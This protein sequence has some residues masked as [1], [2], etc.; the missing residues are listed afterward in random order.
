MGLSRFLIVLLAT[1]GGALSAAEQDAA[2]SGTAVAQQ[3]LLEQ[4]KQI[5]L[6]GK[7]PNGDSI[8]ARVRGDITLQGSQYACAGCHR[9]SGLGS[10]E[11][12]NVIP[13]VIGNSL[14][15]P[16]VTHMHKQFT[17]LGM[18]NETR[19]AYTTQLLARA[20]REG[21][22]PAGRRLSPLMPRFALTDSDVNAV[23]AY[24]SSLSV[25]LPPGIDDQAIHFATIATPGNEA[26]RNAMLG[27]FTAFFDVKNERTRR[28]ISRSQRQFYD[29]AWLYESYR[30]WELHVWELSGPEQ[31]WPAQLQRLYTEQP[32]FAVL[33]GVGSGDWLGVHR[34]CEEQELPCLLPNIPFPPE[35]AD[36]DFYSVYFSRGVALEA[37][38]LATVLSA[39]EQPPKSML[40]VRRDNPAAHAAAA[41]L[42]QALKGE[43][44]VT[45]TDLVLEQEEAASAGFWSE[46]ARE[47]GDSTWVLWLPGE[48]LEGLATLP[49]TNPATIYL[50]ATLNRDLTLLQQHPLHQR[51]TLLSPYLPPGKEA[52]TLGVRALANR[53][54]LPPGEWHVQSSSYLAASLA[55]ETLKQMRS[56]LSRDYFIERIEHMMEDM[57]NS[58]LYP[59]LSLAPGQRF[60][61]K[62]CYVWE[63]GKDFASAKWVVP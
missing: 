52:N 37:Q 43:A 35:Q 60:A 26:A 32:V 14:F 27:I 61:A 55:A 17:A 24:L 46:L 62:G 1:S 41:T 19:P 56:D 10:I 23:A 3:E 58:S 54:K 22:D 45:L 57:V 44:K 16:R 30:P 48:D 33:G 51:F 49:A 31:S 2:P 50:S 12:D 8:R 25:G 36:R 5:Y 7:L 53:H 29:N 21:I 4:G 63:M 6:H 20:L 11:G 38:T 13:P 9:R 47:H 15:S 18:P 42:R 39:A 40:Q 59:R 28:E 34:F